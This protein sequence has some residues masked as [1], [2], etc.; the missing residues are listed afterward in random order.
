MLMTIKFLTAEG[1][2]QMKI[3][4]KIVLASVAMI[5]C[6]TVIINLY[7]YKEVTKL[8]TSENAE[9]LA[10]Y[11]GMGLELL[12]SKYPGDW[13]TDGTNL[14]KGE[15]I[16]NENFDVIDQF[17]AGTN[18]LATIFMNDTRI[19]TNVTDAAGARLINTKAADAVIATVLNGGQAYN[20]SAP[21]QG[22]A[23]Q[24]Y[25]IPLKD[26]SGKV[27]GMW[28]VGVYKAVVN[29]KINAVMMMTFGLSIII[30]ILSSI[31][32]YFLGSTI[33]KAIAMTKEKMVEMENG[34]FNMEFHD[35]LL[36]RKDEVGQIGQ[37]SFHMQQKIQSIVRGIQTESD[38]VMASTERSAI[39]A[40]H[41]H[42]DLEDISAT[43]EELSAGMQETSATTQE[44][45]ASTYELEAE[46]TS[47]REKAGN[48]EILAQ[49]IKE[50][51]AKLKRETEVSQQNAID[52]YE[53][54]NKQLRES[55]EKTNAIEEIKVLS[56]TILDITSKT[57]LL[58][59]NAAI[60][61]A[62]AGEAGKGFAVVADEIRVLA[63]NSKE[64]V[65]KINNITT[66]I[67]EAV[68]HVVSDSKSL[69]TFMDDQV[70]HDYEMF[71]NTSTQYNEDANSVQ[72]VVSEMQ[73]ISNELYGSIKQIRIAIDEV[74][75][76]ASEGAEGTTEIANKVAQIAN[77][78]NDLVKQ[79]NENRASVEQLNKMV[80]FFHI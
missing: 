50:R 30:L 47:M 3:K 72:R 10:N 55:I 25:Y 37:S 8:I 52:I 76:A 63:E 40:E 53:K 60:E 70:I 66:D 79:A 43:T 26:A 6:L 34:H 13:S 42:T 19:S 59:L 23:A 51:A 46:V 54:T 49:E 36:N 65:S 12:D 18:V 5:T 68:G 4:W 29:E 58:A 74:T 20:G 7:Y 73:K 22:K 27:I 21:I 9:E 78:T 38:N 67:S 14:Y 17:T 71:K 64:A 77:K 41:V 44:M 80:A 28:F 56:K 39:S 57:N 45:N 61:A 16:M 31:A 62:R 33:A 32:S 24:T 35:K 2:M 48:G 1:E 75:T 15:T 69:L 11:S